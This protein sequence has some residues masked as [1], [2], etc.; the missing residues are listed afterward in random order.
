M[1]VR[2]HQV[3]FPVGLVAV[4]G[5]G[6]AYYEERLN[7]TAQQFAYYHKLNEHL[8]PRWA[9]AGIEIRVPIQFS[10]DLIPQSFTDDEG[11]V[12]QEFVP[13]QPDYFAEEGALLP[14]LVGSWRAEVDAPAAG[15]VRPAAH[16]YVMSNRDMFLDESTRAEAPD[17]YGIVLDALC[18]GMKIEPPEPEDSRWTSERFPSIKG[19]VSRKELTTIT[20]VPDAPIGGL[21]REFRLYLYAA[22][23]NIQTAFLYVIPSGVSSRENLPDRI[24]LAFETLKV[25]DTIPQHAPAGG[26]GPGGDPGA[27]RF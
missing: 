20:L 1:A 27:T 10:S 25:D 16:F 21:V 18:R 14:G 3:L 6:A 24:G 4:A 12:Q 9:E 13:R 15:E 2:I 11:N 19:Y 7:E 17:F 23:D 8:G 22:G 26:E 5:C